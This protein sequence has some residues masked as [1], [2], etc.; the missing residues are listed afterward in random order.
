MIV[1]YLPKPL[2]TRDWDIIKVQRNMLKHC[3]LNIVEVIPSP[4]A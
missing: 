1:V 4:M 2:Y 3:L